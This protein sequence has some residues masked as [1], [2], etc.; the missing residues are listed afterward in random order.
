MNLISKS[1][2]GAI[3]LFHDLKEDAGARRNAA[4][5]RNYLL[6]RVCQECEQAGYTVEL[7]KQAA[8]FPAM[9]VALELGVQEHSVLIEYGGE[10]WMNIVFGILAQLEK[11]DEATVF[12]QLEAREARA[13]IC[14]VEVRSAAKRERKVTLV[15]VVDPYNL[16]SAYQA[17]RKPLPNTIVLDAD[18]GRPTND[19][20]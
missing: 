19:G 5:N 8:V 11:C 1:I 12:L 2:G 10:D 17:A 20:N 16:V 4:V 9:K 18:D 13:Y 14:C 3:A 7:V 15:D 6:R